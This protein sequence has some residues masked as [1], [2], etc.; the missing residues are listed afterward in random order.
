MLL[1]SSMF[2]FALVFH[3]VTQP[4]AH[5]PARYDVPLTVFAA[6]AASESPSV[7][8]PLTIAPTPS[9]AAM[10]VGVIE[11]PIIAVAAPPLLDAWP[12]AA[13]TLLRESAVAFAPDDA[14]REGGTVRRAL[15]TTGSALRTALRKTF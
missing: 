15:A 2:A 11:A 13:P 10:V 12:S 8:S 9:P 4:A 5:L 14:V 6:A 1:L 7:L 3:S